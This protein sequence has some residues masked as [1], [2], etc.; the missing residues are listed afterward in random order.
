MLADLYGQEVV[1]LIDSGSSSNFINEALASKW[2]HWT[3]LQSSKQVRVA[4]GDILQCT[5]ELVD[6]PIWIFGHGFKLTLKILP[7]SCYDIILGID[8]LEAD[9]PMN[10]DWKE[11]WMSFYY[12]GKEIKLQGISSQVSSCEMISKPELATLVHR[13]QLWCMV[14]LKSIK[15]ARPHLCYLKRYKL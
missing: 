11:K 9:S 14:E 10:V 6:C 13:D 8:W 5:H 7:L 15:T 1:V 3:P 12:L 2:R 4:N